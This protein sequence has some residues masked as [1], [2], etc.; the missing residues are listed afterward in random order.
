M[1]CLICNINQSTR[2]LSDSKL[3]ASIS[4]FTH[5]LSAR[6]SSIGQVSAFT[7]TYR[8]VNSSLSS[9]SAVVAQENMNFGLSEDLSDFGLGD[10]SAISIMDFGIKDKLLS[11][12]AFSVG[13]TDKFAGYKPHFSA[14]SKLYPIEDISFKN[15]FTDTNI[16]VSPISNSFISTENALVICTEENSLLTSEQYFSDV[17]SSIDEGVFIDNYTHNNSIGYLLSDDTQSVVFPNQVFSS[18]DLE[19]KLRVTYPLSHPKFSYFALRASAPFD[20]Y[21]LRRPQEYKI[22]DITLE[23]PSGNL[24]IKYEDITI[25]GDNNFTTYLSKPIINNADQVTWSSGYPYM[26]SGS[27]LFLEIKPYVLTLNFAYN[28]NQHPF[29]SRFNFGYEQSCIKDSSTNIDNPNPFNSLLISSIEIGNSGGIGIKK[30]NALNFFTHVRSKSERTKKI[31]LPNKLFTTDFNNGIY[32]EASSIWRTP[33]YLY[34]NQLNSHS[35]VLLQKVRSTNI[36]YG[37][38]ITLSGSAPFVDSG[39]LI[40]KFDGERD[41]LN[42]YTD[43]AFRLGGNTSFNDARLE[44]YQYQDYFDVDYAELVVIAKKP[45][46]SPDYSIDVVGYS[47]DKLLYVTPAVGGFLQNSGS[48]PINESNVPNISG[49]REF[50]FGLS[51]SSISDQS[52]YFD[53]DISPLGDHYVVDNSILV[54]STDFKTYTIPLEIYQDPRKLGYNKYS[55][56]AYFE[57]LY[58]DICPIPSGASIAHISL[59]LYYKPANALMMHTLGSPATKSAA[60]KPITLLPDG[61]GTINSNIRVSGVLTA[62]STPNNLAS[63]LSRRWRSHTGNIYAGGDFKTNNFDFSFNHKQSDTPFLTSYVDFTKVDAADIYDHKNNY[64]GQ[65]ATYLDIISN[66]GLRYSSDQLFSV[67]TPYKSIGW[68]NNIHDTFDRAVKLND[69]TLLETQVINIENSFALFLRYTP[70]YVIESELNNHLIL[71]HEDNNSWG[72]VLAVEDGNLVLKVKTVDDVIQTITDS[73]LINNYIFPLGILITYNYDSGIINLY[74]DDPTQYLRGTTDCNIISLSDPITFF[75]FS[76]HYGSQSTIPMFLHEIGYSNV[77]NIVNS[78]PNTFNNEISVY[79]FFDSYKVNSDKIDDDISKWKLG[80]FKICSFSPDFDSYTKREGKDYITFNLSHH[81][82]GYS[83]FTNLPLPNNINLSGVSYHTQIENDFL[84]YDISNIPSIDQD[85]FH[86]ISPRISKNLPKGYDFR[87]EALYIET[88]LEHDT[89][90]NLTWPNGQRG[91][92]FIIS[93]YSPTQDNPEFP[94]KL[95]GVVNRSIHYLEPSGCIRKITSKFTFDD[96][97][98]TSE[99][100]ANFE[101]IAYS[102]EFREKYFLNDINSMF[103]QYDIVYPSGSPYNSKIKIHNTNIKSHNAIYLSETKD[104]NISL[105]VSGD[106]YQFDFLNLFGPENGT[107]I[108]Q[109]FSLYVNSNPPVIVHDSG[110]K[111]FIDSSGYFVNPEFL[112]LRIVGNGTVSSSTFEQTFGSMF[113]SSPIM[114]LGLS[115]SGQY[116]SDIVVP[117]HTYGMA[118]NADNSLNFVTSGPEG[119]ISL[120]DNISLQIKGIRPSYN[121]YPSSSMSLHVYNNQTFISNSSGIFNLYLSGFSSIVSDSSGQM[122]LVTLNYPI[123]DLLASKSV[124]IKW[125]SHNIGQSITSVDNVYAYVDADDNIRGVDLACYGDCNK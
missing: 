64:F 19:Y 76:Q 14:S 83:Q 24:I 35:D 91:P 115:I 73:K 37:D 62:F 46:G 113:G 103:L 67:P 111:L 40:L 26:D 47:D 50:N 95:L 120:E 5:G 121:A 72:L 108:N 34:S 71:S 9:A 104:D 116:M 27:P 77:C 109:D 51:N 88:I 21:S 84:R 60:Q 2:L 80:D 39:R 33:D 42:Q 99:P 107:P 8:S 98:D 12:G 23:D 87:E 44:Q 13:K 93:L 118:Y 85:R 112:N 74:T 49:F 122:P 101:P 70:S 97:L 89:Y 63:N 100:W 94:S 1:S 36:D 119:L 117:L 3:S 124:T 58:V 69:E 32:P 78:S 96:I 102:R 10:I 55:L 54:N 86:A 61:N 82:S 114:G 4:T 53:N 68:S 75:G 106:K 59:V 43:G 79:D 18:G 81:G 66:F 31:I 20:S 22:Y 110:L 52:E 28:C 45:A 57:N 30:D 29:D 41:T 17:F 125:D 105:F 7:G 48:L 38:Y 16:N 90:D 92:K 15:K 25:K 65:T 56:S 123:S 6:L 11:T